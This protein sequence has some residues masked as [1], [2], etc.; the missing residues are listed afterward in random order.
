MCVASVQDTTEMI[1]VRA[2]LH[3]DILKVVGRVLHEVAPGCCNDNA[4]ISC[5]AAALWA[6][7][8]HKLSARDHLGLLG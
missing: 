7:M 5:R 4:Y 6:V 1:A 8:Q 2:V 3:H